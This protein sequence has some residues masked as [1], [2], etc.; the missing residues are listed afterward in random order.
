MT[1]DG[2]TI[3]FLQRIRAE[4]GEHLHSLSILFTDGSSLDSLHFRPEDLPN[5][6][7][8]LVQLRALSAST[9]HKVNLEEEHVAQSR[10]HVEVSQRYIEQLQTWIEQAEDY[11]RQRLDQHGVLNLNEAKDFYD[12]HKVCEPS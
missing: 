6:R 3:S 5:V 8:R 7:A 12:K 10:I 2:Y 4:L 9:S 11:L 1:I